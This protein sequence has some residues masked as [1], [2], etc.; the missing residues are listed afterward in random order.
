MSARPEQADFASAVRVGDAAGPPGTAI[1]V[2]GSALSWHQ[3]LWAPLWT[4]RALFFD[5]WLWSWRADHVGTPGYRF[6]AGNHYPDPERTLEREYLARHGI[7]VVVVTGVARQAASVSPLLEIVR[8]GVYDTYVVRDPTTIVTFGDRN[9]S[10]TSVT[11]QSVTASVGAAGAPV[12][13]RVN[14]FPRWETSA[15]SAASVMRRND[16]YMDVVPASPARS[17][18]LVYTLQPFDWVARAL[19]MAGIALLVVLAAA[20]MRRRFGRVRWYAP[21]QEDSEPVP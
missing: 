19:A 16:G 20:P 10:T 18:D 4:Q 12:T 15:E 1:L 21:R 11:N 3:P 17:V 2:L 7:G 5:N 8:Q 14:W 9:A 13:A 6:A